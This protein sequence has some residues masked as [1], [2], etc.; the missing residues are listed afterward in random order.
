MKIGR[1]KKIIIWS[2][3]PEGIIHFCCIST[4]GQRT[5]CW[6]FPS[7]NLDFL[8]L[9]LSSTSSNFKSNN[10]S[11]IINIWLIFRIEMAFTLRIQLFEAF[12][13][14][15]LLSQVTGHSYVTSPISRSFQAQVYFLSCSFQL[16][17]LQIS[18]D[19]YL[20][21][22]WMPRSGLFGPMWYPS[23]SSHTSTNRRRSRKQHHRQLAS[24]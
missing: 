11:R 19:L 13:L 18:S 15:A 6:T 16:I 5:S 8:D 12:M 17:I 20:V 21:W 10:I 9:A 22:S 3:L 4:F 14:F 24:K 1:F 7:L 2:Q 23:F